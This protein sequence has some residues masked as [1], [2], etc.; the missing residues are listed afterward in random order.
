M[1]SYN[2][3]YC[4]VTLKLTFMYLKVHLAIYPPGTYNRDFAATRNLD[5]CKEI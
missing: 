3:V 1:P 4:L 2:R 5:A